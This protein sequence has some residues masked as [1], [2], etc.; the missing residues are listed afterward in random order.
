MLVG[1]VW[2]LGRLRHRH[3]PDPKKSHELWGARGRADSGFPAAGRTRGESA[4]GSRAAGSKQPQTL[5]VGCV[6]LCVSGRRPPRSEC[7]HKGWV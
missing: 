3:L 4:A 5:W 7:A 2:G 1:L 6:G